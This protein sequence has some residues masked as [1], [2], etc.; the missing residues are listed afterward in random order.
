M[1]DYTELLDQLKSGEIESLTIQKQDFL[2]FR[3]VLV[4]RTDFKH[5]RGVAYHHGVTIYSYTEEPSK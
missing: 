2:E 1:T 3:K 5:Y 4:E